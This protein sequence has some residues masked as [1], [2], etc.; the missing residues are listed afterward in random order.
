MRT[1]TD[2]LQ[3]LSVSQGARIK[4]LTMHV[5]RTARTIDAWAAQRV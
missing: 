1:E 4:E 2:T 3:S 5:G